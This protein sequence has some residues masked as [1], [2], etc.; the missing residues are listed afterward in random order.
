[1]ISV[2]LNLLRLVLCSN[3][4]SIIESVPCALEK[5]VY[6]ASFGQNVLYKS[7]EFIWSNVSIKADVSVLTFCL[8]DYPLM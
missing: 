5:N 7:V 8:D 3:I 6:S 1:M 4:W 2:F